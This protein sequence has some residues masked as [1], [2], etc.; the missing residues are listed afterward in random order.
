MSQYPFYIPDKKA[1]PYYDHLLQLDA[2]ID[3]LLPPNERAKETPLPHTVPL[4]RATT[5]QTELGKWQ[6]ETIHLANKHL[7][8]PKRLLELGHTYQ[9]YKSKTSSDLLK[10]PDWSD[11]WQHRFKSIFTAI[12][13][14]LQSIIVTLLKLLLATVTA[15]VPTKVG[16]VSASLRSYGSNKSNDSPRKGGSE[17]G[18]SGPAV[19]LLRNG[20]IHISIYCLKKRPKI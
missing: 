20:I 4:H 8:I 12:E 17:E 7:Y 16:T 15:P 13:G 6:A 19:Q 1:S 10:G 11:T 3:D 18:R 5:E 9:H 14:H 2:L